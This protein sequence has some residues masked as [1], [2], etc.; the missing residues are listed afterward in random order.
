M[1]REGHEIE[2]VLVDRHQ[3][4]VKRVVAELSGPDCEETAEFAEEAGSPG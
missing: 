4:L 2:Q 3:H 1:Q